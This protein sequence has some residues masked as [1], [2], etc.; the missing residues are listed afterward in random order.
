MRARDFIEFK[1]LPLTQ[2]L[3]GESFHPGGLALTHKLA[4][5]TQVSAES[6]VLDIGAG[7]CVS[8]HYLAQKFGASVYAVDV[9][10]D[11]LIN[12]RKDD[13]ANSQNKIH[14]IQGDTHHLPIASNSI[15]V[16]FCECVLGSFRNRQLALAEAY[17]VLKPNGYL[18]ISDVYL[19]EQMPIELSV[20]INRWLRMCSAYS[21][22]RCK[23]SIA[24]GGFCNLKFNDV[25]DHLLETIHTIETKLLKPD[26]KLHALICQH[27]IEQRANW[28]HGIPRRLAHFIYDGGAGYYI[29]TAQKPKE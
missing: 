11:H 3:L 28:Q 4:L 10:L 19:N 8:T 13:I 17:R 26:P 2:M 9:A 5:K 14:L 29:L 25:S 21:A 18:A 16:V 27:S 7:R 12:S 22:L 24:Q 6:I 1:H 15:D 20:E 23:E